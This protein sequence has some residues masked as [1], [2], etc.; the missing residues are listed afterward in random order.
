MLASLSLIL[1]GRKSSRLFVLFLFCFKSLPFKYFYKDKEE[2]KKKKH[3]KNNKKKEWRT[4]ENSRERKK[5]ESH[6]THCALEPT[7]ICA[8]FLLFLYVVFIGIS[9]LKQRTT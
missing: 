2:S 3:N 1:D 7:M 6:H 8:I 9:L 4:R 5:R